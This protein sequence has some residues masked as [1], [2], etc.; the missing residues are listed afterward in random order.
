MGVQ[1]EE[2]IHENKGVAPHPKPTA[3]CCN[4]LQVPPCS[5]VPNGSSSCTY[6]SDG[7]VGHA[8]C[9]LAGGG[10]HGA[11]GE[12]RGEERKVRG[13]NECERLREGELDS[14]CR[15]KVEGTGEA[16]KQQGARNSPGPRP[17]GLHWRARTC[18]TPC[19]LLN[20]LAGSAESQKG[21]NTECA[22]PVTC[23]VCVCVCVCV[24]V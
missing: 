17:R 20:L 15:T 24:C 5:T 13:S 12:R 4:Y 8:W 10:T 11:S 2:P 23:G 21:T 14:E 6:M 9:L 3:I 16:K 18:A 1:A 7:V 22:A 19:V